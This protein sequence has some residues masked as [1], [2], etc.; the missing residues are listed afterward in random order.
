MF[1]DICQYSCYDASSII[2]SVV[3]SVTTLS[4]VLVQKENSNFIVK[5]TFIKY[6]FLQNRPLTCDIWP[7]L[8]WNFKSFCVCLVLRWQALASMLDLNQTYLC[9]YLWFFEI[10]SY[11]V[12]TNLD[13][14][15]LCIPCWPWIYSN[16]SDSDAKVLGVQAYVTNPGS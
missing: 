11:Y 3:I 13:W 4:I 10:G 1:I 7:K 14:N 2:L 6:I 8:T 15:S 5:L 9:L 12:T 16:T